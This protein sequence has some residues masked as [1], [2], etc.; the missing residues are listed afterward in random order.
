MAV[1]VIVCGC[2]ESGLA[3]SPARTAYVGRAL[4]EVLGD[5]QR[6]GLQI[7]FSSDLVKPDMRVMAEP[8]SSE[9]RAR[10]REILK[11]HGLTTREGP[12]GAVLVVRAP[13]ATRPPQQPNEQTPTAGTIR[14]VVV[15]AGTNTPLEGVLLQI[16]GTSHKASTGGDGTFA[17]DDLPAGKHTLHVSLVGYALARRA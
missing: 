11:P 12:K 13:D 5:L 9:V 16:V 1:A 8:T 10:L 2:L 3:Q 4:A 7:V 17:F 6:E 14:G 15:D